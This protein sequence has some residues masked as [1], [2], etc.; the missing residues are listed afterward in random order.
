MY[1]RLMSVYLTKE[2]C[3]FLV[4]CVVYPKASPAK[5]ICTRKYLCTHPPVVATGVE[6]AYH[7]PDRL[8]S[9]KV[10]RRYEFISELFF[11]I[12]KMEFMPTYL[13]FNLYINDVRLKTAV[14]R[15]Y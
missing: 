1:V 13:Y 2:P 11:L 15:Q 9:V 12:M 5:P 4:G 8:P 10:T 3:I 14:Q 7:P 6:N